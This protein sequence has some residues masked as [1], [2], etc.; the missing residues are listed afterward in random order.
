MFEAVVRQAEIVRAL[1][2]EPIVIG[3]DE[4]HAA[5]DRWRL[6]HAETHYAQPHGPRALGYS[7]EFAGI[8]SA[9]RLNLLHCHGIWQGHVAATGRWARRSGGPLVIS[10]HGM[11]DPWITQRGRWK[12]LG[13]RLVWERRAAHAARL[14]HALTHDEGADIRQELPQAPLAVIPNPAPSLASRSG[15]LPA[16]VALYLGRIHEKKNISALIDGWRMARPRLPADATLVIAGWGDAQGVAA[17]ERATGDG[18]DGIRFVGMAF[19][20]QKA[21]LLDIARFMVLPSL[22][23]GLPMAVLEAWAAGLPAILSP[24]CHLPEGV[25]HCA[26]LECGTAPE[27]I[28]AALTEAFALDDE[29]WQAMSDA[30]TDLARGPFGFDTVTAQ[31]GNAYGRLLG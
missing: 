2:G 6:G 12:K 18:D 23:E 16:P 8:L 28:A 9:A 19:G 11:L 20:S 3:L 25:A 26:A 22:S 14:F 21:A 5:E 30:A 1:G 29:H 13:A 24:A 27:C 17:L 7:K 31:W 4:D 15:R 10:P